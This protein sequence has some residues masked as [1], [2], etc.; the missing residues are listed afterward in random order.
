MPPSPNYVPYVLRTP[1]P[2]MYTRFATHVRGFN[3]GQDNRPVAPTTNYDPW[4]DRYPTP[5]PA[6][7]I[8]SKEFWDNIDI[9]YSAYF[10]SNHDLPDHC[11]P[12]PAGYRSNTMWDQPPVV[13][14]ICL[15]LGS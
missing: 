12:P 4:A 9:P 3:V 13:T 11:T 2:S 10:P 14:R 1:S 5:P 15:R 6:A 8:A 7:G